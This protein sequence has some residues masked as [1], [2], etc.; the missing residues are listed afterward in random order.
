M[1]KLLLILLCLPLIFSCGEK[2]SAKDI[3]V[4]EINDECELVDAAIIVIDEMTELFVKYD[5]NFKHDIQAS[6]F[7]QAAREKFKILKHKYIELMRKERN[8]ASSDKIMNP[9]LCRNNQNLRKKLNNLLP[10]IYQLLHSF[11]D[12]TKQMPIIPILFRLEDEAEEGEP[13]DKAIESDD[14]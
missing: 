1:K 10:P 5:M 9:A 14:K 8:P 7:P 12:P 6:D 3:N 13:E 11:Q 4:S 2:K